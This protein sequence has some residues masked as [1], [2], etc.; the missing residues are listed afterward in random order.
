MAGVTSWLEPL[1]VTSG[2]EAAA[3]VAAGRAAFL[4]GGP[5][6]FTALRLFEAETSRVVPWDADLPEAFDALRRRLLTPPAPWAGFAATEPVVM[7]ILNCTPDSFSD[8]GRHLET[9]A[10]IAAGLAMAEAGAAIIDV[11]GESTRPGSEEVPPA[12]EMRRILPV[13]TALASRGL[14]LS[15]DT[16]HAA[17]MEAALAAGAK[18]INDV[19]GLTFD[20]AARAVVAR[21]GC[22]VVLMHMRGTPATMKGLAQYRDVAR[23]VRNELAE[24]FEAA[25]ASGIAPEQIALDPGFG[26][27][28]E[29]RQNLELMQRLPHLAAFGRPLLVGVSRK[30]LIGL[31]SGEGEAA[32]RA[33]GSIAAGLYALSRGA[34]L[35]RVHD[36]P[37][38]VQAVRVWRDLMA[39]SSAP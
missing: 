36:V 18:I 38:T 17:T 2:A 11:G 23:D 3:L 20:P 16:R 13:I 14:T 10:A 24:R 32:R 26:F 34:T 39:A 6:A 9:D 29:G 22:P 21:A 28:K 31:S 1:G 37:E 33:P 25:C 7:G 30:R 12:E 15:V 8:G 27:A 4:W 5:L 19:S 35:L